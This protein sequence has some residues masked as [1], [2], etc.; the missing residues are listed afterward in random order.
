MDYENE[1]NGGFMLKLAAFI[2]DKRSLIFLLIG[3]AMVFSLISRNWV[4]VE[5]DLTAYLPSGSKTKE[6]LEVMEQQFITYGAADLMV[7]NI[8]YEEA[9]ALFEKIKTIEGVQSV[10]FDDTTEHYSKASALYSV[11][12]D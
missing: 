7:A 10:A 1:N 2:V 6:G 11:T 5:N 9:N 12:F 4:E 8:S 3:I